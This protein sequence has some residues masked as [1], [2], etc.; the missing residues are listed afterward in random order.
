MKNNFKHGDVIIDVEAN[1]T[2]LR[3]S[4]ANII[5]IE[6]VCSHAKMIPNTIAFSDLLSKL[7]S[8]EMSGRMLSLHC[9]LSKW[10]PQNR[11]P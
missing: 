10:C 6:S 3:Q 2:K 11:C 4:E 9:L 1:D 7:A 8:E 5:N